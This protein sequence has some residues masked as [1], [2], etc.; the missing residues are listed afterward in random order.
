MAPRSEGDFLR[1]QGHTRDTHLLS[2]LIITRRVEP[3][4]AIARVNRPR[5][6]RRRVCVPACP[7]DARGARRG[8]LPPAATHVP[9]P[10]SYVQCQG[11]P[12]GS[13]LSTLLCSLCY[14]DMES[15]LFSGIQRDG[16][17]SPLCVCVCVVLPPAASC[18]GS[19]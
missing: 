12:Q 6:T 1:G 8:L 18:L 2:A 7:R 3:L 19:S 11:I 4:A 16:Y 9:S 15:R 10:R 5:F 13:I 14:G 17:G